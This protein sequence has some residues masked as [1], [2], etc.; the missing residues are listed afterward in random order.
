MVNDSHDHVIYSD[1]E[2]P[3]EWAVYA[4]ASE[5]GGDE[6]Y[7]NVKGASCQFTFSGTGITW[8]GVKNLDFG[9]ADV[10]L[11]GVL[12]ATVDTYNTT[13]LSRQELFTKTGLP[14]GKHTFKNVVKG[15]KNAASTG[16]YVIVDAFKVDTS[17]A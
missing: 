10:Y 15:T 8:V 16:Y 3:S 13:R 2:T 14:D 9:E 4:S 12:R 1:D 17:G 7:A 5:I 11:D 6:H